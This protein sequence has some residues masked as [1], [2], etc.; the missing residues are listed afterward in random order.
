M[1]CGFFRELREIL[2]QEPGLLT[3]DRVCE[4]LAQHFGGTRPH[5]GKQWQEPDIT[6]RDTPETILRRHSVSRRTAY[7]WVS[8][9]KR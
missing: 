5:I 3:R 7:N 4:L 2:D 6:H 8:G 1:V 9:W